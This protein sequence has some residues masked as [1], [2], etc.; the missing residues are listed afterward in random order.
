MSAIGVGSDH[1]FGG[2]LSIHLTFKVVK[3]NRKLGGC[4][5]QSDRIHTSTGTRH[6]VRISCDIHGLFFLS[7]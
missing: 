6:P 3:C 5:G 1:S 2:L 7:P 4:F